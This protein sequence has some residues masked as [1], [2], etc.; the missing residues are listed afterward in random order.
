M[1]IAKEPFAETIPRPEL[2]PPKL[3]KLEIDYVPIPPFGIPK[4]E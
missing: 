4:F 1:I 2:F 3:F